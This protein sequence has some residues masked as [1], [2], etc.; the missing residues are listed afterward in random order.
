MLTTILPGLR[1]LRTPLATG[2]LWLFAVFLVFADWLPDGDADD[3]ALSQLIEWAGAVG[4]ATL[5]GVLTF[6]A[7]LLGSALCVEDTDIAGRQPTLAALPK[8]MMHAARASGPSQKVLLHYETLILDELKS[9]ATRVGIEDVLTKLLT[10]RQVFEEQGGYE[11][12]VQRVKERV[13]GDRSL[14]ENSLHNEKLALWDDYDRECAEG[15]FRLSVIPPLLAIV[16]AVFVR[17]A[18]S[19]GFSP[20]LVVAVL[21]LLFA[22]YLITVIFGRGITRLANAY[23]VL[24]IAVCMDPNRSPF[25]LELRTFRP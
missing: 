19:A 15:Q 20:L 11:F 5:L 24:V 10:T 7:Y 14:I 9:A 21:V 23:E 1:D 12:L 13:S 18:I 25:L 22:L 6:V 4:T 8:F 17:T 16:F 2:Y 3:A